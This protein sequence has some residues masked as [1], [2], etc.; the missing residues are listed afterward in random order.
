[1]IIYTIVMVQQSTAAE[2]TII[3]TVSEGSLS[4]IALAS[5]FLLILGEDK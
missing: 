2:K 1:M 3:N 4:K 5:L